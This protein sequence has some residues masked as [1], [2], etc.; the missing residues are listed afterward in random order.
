[1]FGLALNS[2]QDRLW[3]SGGGADQIYAYK[4]LG[5]AL[6]KSRGPEIPMPEGKAQN[7]FRSGLLLDP[8]GNRLYSLN[9]DAGTLST[10][11]LTAEQGGQVVKTAPIAGRPYDRVLARNGSRLYVS[12]W[13]GRSV[14]AVDPTELRVLARIGVG[15][16]PN[17][18]VLHPKDDRLFVAC[19]SS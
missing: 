6:E 1:W 11:D 19:A 4:L 10:L 8:S 3:W 16:H 5:T 17:Q 9:I 18:L 2:A 14:V 13:A 12:D 15:E 7:Q